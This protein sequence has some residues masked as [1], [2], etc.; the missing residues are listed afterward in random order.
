MGADIGV[1]TCQL[2]PG[3]YSKGNREPWKVFSRDGT[4]CILERITFKCKGILS[5][6]YQMAKSFKMIIPS[7]GNVSAC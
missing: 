7:A 3:F 2:G 1:L 4:G 5:F 6:S